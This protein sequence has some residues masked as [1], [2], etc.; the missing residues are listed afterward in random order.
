VKHEGVVE[1]KSGG[2]FRESCETS[3][4]TLMHLPLEEKT[5]TNDDPDRNGKRGIHDMV[6]EIQVTVVEDDKR[7]RSGTGSG[8]EGHRMT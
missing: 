1:D 7:S 6:I 2:S 8:G 3:S 5:R 4:M